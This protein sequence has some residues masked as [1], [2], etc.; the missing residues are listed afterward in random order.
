MSGAWAR[1]GRQAVRRGAK[2]GEGSIEGDA[3]QK[4]GSALLTMAL[5]SPLLIAAFFGL[6]IVENLFKNW[7]D[8][9]SPIWSE[10]TP[11]MPAVMTC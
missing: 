5:L 9:G 6:P 10:R 3:R 2:P 1:W 4:A 11:S 8:S 7:S